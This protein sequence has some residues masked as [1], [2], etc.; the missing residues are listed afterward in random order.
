[1]YYSPFL[2]SLTDVVSRAA[3]DAL[4]LN[5]CRYSPAAE[6]VDL[7]DFS[8]ITAPHIPLATRV[9]VS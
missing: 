8:W 6:R 3:A 1:M 4:V 2:E 7:P 9:D 5:L